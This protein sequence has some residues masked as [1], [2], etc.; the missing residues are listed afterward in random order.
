VYY[1]MGK[2]LL[3]WNR[4]AESLMAFQDAERRLP[5]S[6]R[7][8]G[9]L[10][11]LLASMNRHEEAA[12]HFERALQNAKPAEAVTLHNE[13][14]VVLIMLG[15]RGEAAAHLQAALKLNPGFAPAR[16]NLQKLQKLAH[17]P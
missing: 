15:R 3:R 4:P 12:V 5:G 10:A 13:F 1:N 9:T 11:S 16:A 2:A 7:V 17:P 14:A 6:T 8:E